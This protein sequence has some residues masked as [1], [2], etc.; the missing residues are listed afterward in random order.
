MCLLSRGEALAPVSPV[1]R[2]IESLWDLLN[3]RKWERRGHGQANED[4]RVLGH[5]KS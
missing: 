3:E 5:L 4:K 1:R 2:L